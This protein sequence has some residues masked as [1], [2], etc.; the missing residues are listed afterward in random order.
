MTSVTRLRAKLLG[1]VTRATA[2]VKAAE[3]NRVAAVRAAKDSG[4]FTV[5][6]IAEAAGITRDAVYKMLARAE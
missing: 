5:E 4:Q 3:R 1:N 6:Q 2:T